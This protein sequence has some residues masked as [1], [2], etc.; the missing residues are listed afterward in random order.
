MLHNRTMLALVVAL[1]VIGSRSSTALA[2]VSAPAEGGDLKSVLE[3]IGKMEK[4]L[5]KEMHEAFKNVAADM[6]NVKKQVADLKSNVEGKILAIRIGA[7]E[8]ERRIETLEA[9]VKKLNRALTQLEQTVAKIPSSSYVAKS[10]PIPASSRVMLV[11]LYAE[12]MVFYI[13]QRSYTVRAN[14]SQI[15]DAVPPGSMTYEV[16]SPTWGRRAFST[17]SLQTGETL[18]LTA[19]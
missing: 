1:A 9:E 17:T 4:S 5:T 12:D 11:N 10:A 8:S 18:T 7:E 13:N 15:V 6:D 14:A 16:Y 19:R 2:Q 3:R